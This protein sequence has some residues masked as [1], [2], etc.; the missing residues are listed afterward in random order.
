MFMSLDSHKSEMGP[1]VKII[2]SEIIHKVGQSDWDSTSNKL[3]QNSFF[4]RKFLLR[5]LYNILKV[6]RNPITGN[7]FFG[8]FCYPTRQQDS[9]Q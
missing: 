8:A 4:H 3:Q 7:W 5:H 9:I 6:L 1:D 2:K